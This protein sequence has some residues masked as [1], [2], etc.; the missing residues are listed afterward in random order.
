MTRRFVLIALLLTACAAPAAAQNAPRPRVAF[1]VWGGFAVPWGEMADDLDLGYTVSGDVVVNIEGGVSAYGGYALNHFSFVSPL[2]LDEEVAGPEVGLRYNTGIDLLVVFP[3]ELWANTGLT[4]MRP[5]AVSDGEE[6]V[7]DDRR[8]GVQGGLGMTSQL[9]RNFA[10]SLGA[11]ISYMPGGDS[12]TL[13]FCPPADCPV[14]FATVRASLS[15][16]P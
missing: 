7:A 1:E 5:R 8:L 15:I 14:S 13:D 12:S 4:W 3:F 9:R 2:G 16:T 11:Q 6:V 10:L